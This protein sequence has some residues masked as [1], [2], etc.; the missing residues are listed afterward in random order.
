MKYSTQDIKD[1]QNNPSY[2]VIEGQILP[3]DT[4]IM[5]DGEKIIAESKILDGVMVYERVGRN[6]FK[7]DFEFNI[8]SNLVQI[9]G[10]NIQVDKGNVFPQ[11]IIQSYFTDIWNPDQVVKVKNTYLNGI[12]IKELIIKKVNLK[13]VRGTINVQGSINTLENYSDNKGGTL[14]IT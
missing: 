12:G 2:I 9:P 13:T 4:L 1:P 7:V 3:P 10:V 8:K 11:D 6:P 5:L 14:I